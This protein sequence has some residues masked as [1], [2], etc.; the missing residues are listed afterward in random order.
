MKLFIWYDVAKAS[1]RYHDEGGVVVIADS[2]DRARELIEQAAPGCAAATVAPSLV[3]ECDGP[4]HIT[5][6]PNAGCC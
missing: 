5:I 6:H 2:L 1:S 3:R 4:E